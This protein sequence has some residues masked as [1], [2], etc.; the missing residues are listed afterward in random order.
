M[1]DESAVS[2]VFFFPPSFARKSSKEDVYFYLNLSC[3]RATFV[4][5]A[6]SVRFSY[7][8]KK[9]ETTSKSV[10]IGL[11]STKRTHIFN[12]QLYYSLGTRQT[13]IK[14]YIQVR[15]RFKFHE[16]KS[17]VK[18]VVRDCTQKAVETSQDFVSLWFFSHCSVSL[19]TFI[20]IVL[21]YVC[22][23]FFLVLFR[24]D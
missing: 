3:A 12:L 10:D 14:N 23:F 22:P 5:D 17:R 20:I 2:P 16:E 15:E 13:T 11:D 4:C 1:R 8:S 21:F 7:D 19:R 6:V 24:H 18:R 9:T